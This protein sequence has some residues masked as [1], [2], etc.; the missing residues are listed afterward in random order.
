MEKYY[1]LIFVNTQG[2]LKAESFLKSKGFKIVIMPTPTHI[3]Q[4]CGISIR[5]TEEEFLKTKEFIVNREIDIKHIYI[6]DEGKF[7]EIKL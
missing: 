6:K 2:A 1:L 5:L 4:S 3:T 7:R